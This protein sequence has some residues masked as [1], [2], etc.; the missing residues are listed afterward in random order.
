MGT[1]LD[2]SVH[3][4][5]NNRVEWSVTRNEKV[6]LLRSLIPLLVMMVLAWYSSFNGPEVVFETIQINT[7]VFL[8]GVALYFSAE[9][10][11]GA[12]FTFIDRMFIYFYVAIGLQILSEFTLMIDE[13]LYQ[14]T[15]LVWQVSIPFAVAIFL[16]IVWR[17]IKAISRVG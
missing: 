8:A 5:T 6:S 16:V 17:K 12:S 1:N 13:R 3:V 9:K 2:T 14:I 15:H 4:R 10:P 11:R 7:T